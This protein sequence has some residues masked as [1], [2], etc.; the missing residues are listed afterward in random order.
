[1]S[2][3]TT[4]TSSGTPQRFPYYSPPAPYN[5]DSD[6]DSD[7]LLAHNQHWAY[8]TPQQ[9]Y[10]SNRRRCKTITATLRLRETLSSRHNST[11]FSTSSAAHS[12]ATRKLPGSFHH[13]PQHIDTTGYDKIFAAEW[14]DDENVVVGTK[15]GKLVVCDVDKGRRVEI[16]TVRDLQWGTHSEESAGGGSGSGIRCIAINP[17]RTLIAVGVGFPL[18]CVEIFSL[19]SFQVVGVLQGHEDLV[20]SLAWISD[21][22]L[23]TGSRDATIALWDVDCNCDGHIQPTRRIVSPSSFGA[24]Y[25]IHTPTFRA[26]KHRDRVR[27]LHYSPTTHTL[28]TLSTDGLLKLWDC[29]TTATTHSLPPTT[30]STIILRYRDELTCLAQDSSQNTNLYAVGSAAKVSIIDPRINTVATAFDSCDD[31]WGVRSLLF[32]G[33]M[34]VVGG[35]K[36]RIAF[37]DARAAKYISW[38]E[39]PPT[40]STSQQPTAAPN[41]ANDNSSEEEETLSTPESHAPPSLTRTP[42][43]HPHRRLSTHLLTHLPANHTAWHTTGEGY[44]LPNE[45]WRSHFRGYAV[46]NAPYVMRFAERGGVGLGRLF[47]AGG[48]LQVNLEGSWA[49]VFW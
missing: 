23:A 41:D 39:S 9:H 44:L 46:K 20:F 8:P 36:G 24:P 5:T 29:R 14:L 43:L 34:V 1:M 27:D 37:W 13:S 31:G 47:V 38:V 25:S 10:H 48:P 12:Y 22:C 30:T 17:S 19:P 49:G 21:T 40:S 28:A 33:E 18:G 45:V 16:P 11:T 32:K 35:G 26:Q 42:T 7:S 2:P 4:T 3:S 15:C 6:S